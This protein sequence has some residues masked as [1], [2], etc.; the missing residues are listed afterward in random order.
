MNAR[1]IYT[2]LTTKRKGR[3]MSTPTPSEV[4]ATPMTSASGEA[5]TIRGCL[6][7]LLATLWRQGSGF[8][9]KR[10]FGDSSWEWDFHVALAAAGHITGRTDEEFGGFEEVDEQAGDRLIAEA[11]ESFRTPS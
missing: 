7:D 6:T 3:P 10:P 11:I 8:S 4:L 9:G 2:P 1:S 5:S